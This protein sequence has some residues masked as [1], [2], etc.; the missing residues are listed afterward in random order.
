M[1]TDFSKLVKSL[2]LGTGAVLAPHI[3]I[4]LEDNPGFAPTITVGGEKIDDGQ[5]HPSA[6]ALISEDSLYEEMSKPVRRKLS[7]AEKKTFDCGHMWHGYIQA[8]LVRMG[9]VTPKNVERHY[10]WDIPDSPVAANPRMRGTMISG[11]LDLQDV[12]IPGQGSWLVDIKTA[13]ADTF[14]KIEQTNLFE[15]YKAQV[16]IYGE[17]SDARNMLILV[18]RKDSP[19]LFREIQIQRDTDLLAGIYTRWGN[20]ANRL[21][22]DENTRS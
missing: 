16:N 14:N 11:T 22:Y 4:F 18:V 8:A 10:L 15:K 5:F 1:P 13:S 2:G 9:F 7:A 6:H 20:V 19:H 12:I 3:D 21:K 17:R